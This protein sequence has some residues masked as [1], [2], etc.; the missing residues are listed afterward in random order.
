MLYIRSSGDCHQ[1]LTGAGVWQ[2]IEKAK[3]VAEETA[4]RLL[5]GAAVFWES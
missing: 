5:N 2:T 3:Q 4:T 1:N